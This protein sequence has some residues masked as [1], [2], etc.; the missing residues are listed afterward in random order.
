MDIR[1][2]IG[3]AV[4]FL[5][6]ENKELFPFSRIFWLLFGKFLVRNRQAFSTISEKRTTSGG[7]YTN[8]FENFLE[9]LSHLN[10][11]PEFSQFSVEWFVFR[12]FNNFRILTGK[13]FKDVSAPPPPGGSTPF[14][15]YI[16]MCGPKGYTVLI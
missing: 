2:I 9:F 5:L 3:L 10:F 11:I 7:I 15:G 4:F 14:C 1:H 12:A 6:T 13:L 16:G 8:I